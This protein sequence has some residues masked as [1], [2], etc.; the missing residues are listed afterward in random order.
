[1]KIF[2]TGASGFVGSAV[3]Q[4]LLAHGHQAVGLA[5][6]EK[7]AAAIIAAGAQVL[8]GDLTDL[9][10]LRTGASTAD[11]VIHLAYN[12]DDFSKLAES[13]KADLAAIEAMGSVLAGKPF[14][15]A[16]GIAGFAAGQPIS[17]DDQPAGGHRAPSD[18]LTLALAK[19]GLR[20]SLVRLPPTVHGEHDQGFV[21]YL[22][23]AAREK[24]V[25]GYLDA[26]ANRWAAVHRLDAAKVFRLALEK[27]V[28][29]SIFH[30]VAEEGIAMKTISE[31]IGRALN[32]SAISMGADQ[33]AATF[34]WLSR[35]AG[36]DLAATSAI[37]RATLGWEPKHVGLLA[38]LDA[39]HYTRG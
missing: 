38:D 32:V 28:A 21:A 35:F 24:K 20:S 13:A 4:E 6:S 36:A 39:G 12:H 25:A 23:R 22:V 30:A 10:R 17:E 8:R 2:V 3:V 19:R 5:R 1:M 11:G 26:G 15:T 37:T 14:V 18:L 29:G 7:S 33:F 34:T 9:E 27:G 31:A 16:T